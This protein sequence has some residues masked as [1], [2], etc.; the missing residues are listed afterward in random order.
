[1]IP[2]F[3]H[4][5]AM[6]HTRQYH[7]LLAELNAEIARIGM[8]HAAT[9]SCG[10]RCASCCVSFSVLAIEAAFLRQA[11]AALPLAGQE[12]IERNLAEDGDRCP[13]LI[14]ALCGI[15]SARPVICR[16]Q[17]LPLAYVDEEREAIE[18]S[19]CPLNFP[20]RYAFV[21][22]MLLFMDGFNA[23]LSELNRAWCKK[24]GLDPDRRISLREVVCLSPPEQ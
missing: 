8:M 24:L 12:R 5:R 20:D 21:P 6:P 7:Q 18:V 16:T 22:E 23:R 4:D 11:V 14:D 17:G 1:L 2:F 9:L 3:H 13:L 10:P 15:Y 19:A